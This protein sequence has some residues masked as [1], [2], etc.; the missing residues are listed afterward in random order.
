MLVRDLLPRDKAVI[1]SASETL[2]LSGI[3]DDID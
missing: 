3:K 1:T 2:R